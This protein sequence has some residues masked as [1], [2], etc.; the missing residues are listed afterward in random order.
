MLGCV[1]L[2]TLVIGRFHTFRQRGGV[3]WLMLGD[4]PVALAVLDIVGIVALGADKPALGTGT[5]PFADPFAVDALPPVPIDFTV[6]FAAQE[7]RLIVT[8]RIVAMVD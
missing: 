2:S 3:F 5:G 4:T 7:L 6:A 8:D 1:V